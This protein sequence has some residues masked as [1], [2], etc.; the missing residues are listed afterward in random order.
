MK[1]VKTTTAIVSLIL[2]LVLFSGQDANAQDFYP[3]DPIGAAHTAMAGATTA[4]ANDPASIY[5]NPASLVWQRISIGTGVQP[6]RFDN[7]FRSYWVHLYNRNTQYN[8]PLSLIIQGWDVPGPRR[9]MMI[10]FPIAYGLSPRTPAAVDIKWAFERNDHGKWVGG[11]LAD[12]GFLARAPT[13]SVIG[14]VL[15]NLPLGKERFETLKKRYEFGVAYGGGPITLSLS[16]QLEKIEDWKFYQEFEDRWNVGL[17]LAP[18][19]SIALRM[20]HLRAEDGNRYYTGGLGLKAIS[21]MSVAGVA[22]SG[23]GAPF[24]APYEVGY[25]VMYNRDEKSFTHFISYNYF[26]R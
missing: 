5:H 12:V 19:G 10:G 17:E 2:L 3:F 13:G 20:G 6:H 23:S 26:V 8:F 9:N 24:T 14:L 18:A 25:S 7:M 1:N 16:T 15:R 21:G 22:R 4:L 11:A